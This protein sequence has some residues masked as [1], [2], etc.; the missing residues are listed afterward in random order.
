[1]CVFQALHRIRA[2]SPVQ[3]RTGATVVMALVAVLACCT[4][5]SAQTNWSIEGTLP[6]YGEYNGPPPGALVNPMPYAVFIPVPPPPPAPWNL[7]FAPLNPALGGSA[8][9]TDGNPLTGGPTVPAMIH[10]DGLTVEMSTVMGMFVTSFS[11]GGGPLLPGTI[12]GVG[13]DSIADIIWLTDGTLCLA[14]ALPPAPGVIPPVVVPPFPLPL[15]AGVPASGLD[16]D[17]FTGTLWFCDTAGLVTNC[18]VGGAPLVTF[19]AGPLLPGVPM[20]LCID[21]TNGNVQVTDG[22]LVAEFL[23]GGAPAAAG[24]FDRRRRR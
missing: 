2:S 9:D 10:S 17:P 14:T 24:A 21:K 22:M 23:P 15:P 8:V 18:L 7:P 19:P 4:V 1:M 3:K 6:S 12:S 11:A 20:G 13:Y 5:A 16:W